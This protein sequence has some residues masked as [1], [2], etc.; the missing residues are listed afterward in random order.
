MRALV[1]F[2]FV[3]L[4]LVASDVKITL[5]GTA[6]D[7]VYK[8][9]FVVVGGDAGV[10]QVFKNDKLFASFALPLVENAFG[11]SAPKIYSVDLQADQ[12]LIVSESDA[13]K[14]RKLALYSFDG[15]IIKELVSPDQGEMIRKARFVNSSEIFVMEIGGTAS[16][17]S[18][19]GK[20]VYKKDILGSSFSDFDLDSTGAKVA[21][22]SES[23][24][25]VVINT[26][27][28]KVAKRLVGGSRDNVYKLSWQKDLIATSGQD[29]LVAVFLPN[30]DVKRIESDF[31]I[32]AVAISP[33][34]TK[35]AYVKDE[36]STI[37]VVD[38]ATLSEIAVLKGHFAMVSNI[39]FIDDRTLI[40]GGDD[41]FLLK[42]RTK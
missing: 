38:L 21:I 29:R 35:L 37:A 31:L 12:L 14:G 42:W 10:V 18:L 36:S 20:Q 5:K 6:I 32:S 7:V 41:S 27:D 13:L 16:L 39:V 2:L 8:D 25:V 23:G 30:G 28:G 26:A 40:S 22:A 24:E 19:D 9:S 33:N 3:V 15:K 11:K 4:C 1:S 34:A 17:I